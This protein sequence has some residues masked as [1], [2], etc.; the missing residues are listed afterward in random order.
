MPNITKGA[1]KRRH[2]KFVTGG[3]RGGPVV[4]RF[5]PNAASE[6]RL[7]Q[8]LATRVNRLVPPPPQT[9]GASRLAIPQEHDNNFFDNYIPEYEGSAETGASQETNSNQTHTR[10]RRSK[11]AKRKS[12]ADN[13]VAAEQRLVDIS[14]ATGEIPPCSCRAREMILVRH[15]SCEG[16]SLWVLIPF[17]RY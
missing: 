13:W 9:S 7:K 10:R 14:M 6:A 3:I 2:V 8:T 5:G 17:Q 15:I 12:V 4:Q 1:I 16:G 11:A